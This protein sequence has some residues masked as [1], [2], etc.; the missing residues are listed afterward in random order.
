MGYWISQKNTIVP[1]LP[2]LPLAEVSS[3]TNV[4]CQPAGTPALPSVAPLPPCPT[5]DSG[6]TQEDANWQPQLNTFSIID[7][8]DSTIDQATHAEY[9]RVLGQFIENDRATFGKNRI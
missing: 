5:T 1:E 4:P 2:T 6:S 3:E 8:N 9:Q 7:P